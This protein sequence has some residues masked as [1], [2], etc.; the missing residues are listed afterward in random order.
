MNV[1]VPD[2]SNSIALAMELLQSCTKSMVLYLEPDA[3]RVAKFDIGCLH[4]ITGLILGL[5]PV[6]ERQCYF[7]T[8]SLIGWAQA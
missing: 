8:T 2:C 5:H 7:V 1:L 3:W 6:S 4:A